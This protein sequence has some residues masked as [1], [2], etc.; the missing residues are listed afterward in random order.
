MNGK[1][2]LSAF[3]DEYAVSFDEQ[4]S[5]MK[6]L[7]ISHIE[8]RIVNGKGVADLTDAD[9][10]YVKEKLCEYGISVSA[11]GSP[12]GKI[13]LDGDIEGHMLAAER[14]ASF[15]R[16]LGTDKMRIFS[17]YAPEGRDITEF[18]SEVISLLDRLISIADKHGVTLCHENE[19]KIY[20][21]TP[22]RCLELLEH[23]GGRLGCVFDMGN[24]ALDGIDSL[25]AYAM[26]R[27]YVKYFHVKDSL[28]AGAIVPPGCGEAN[29]AEI[30]RRHAEAA[31]EP[32]FITLE[33][34]LQTFGGL[35]ALTDRGFDNPYKFEN[36]AV[37]FETALTRLKEILE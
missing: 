20:G 34:H 35:H 19:A 33:P 30:L 28:S 27:P 22:E 8:L 6:R 17:F 25:R 13:R 7:G 21:D 14:L 12:I 24:F 5:A 3:S 29:I 37:A 10:K 18:K 26:L 9:F 2:I 32:F 11:I 15:A 1:I 36:T 4:L 16:E 23:F 31:S